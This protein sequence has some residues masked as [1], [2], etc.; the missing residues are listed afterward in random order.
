VGL[1]IRQ[2][3]G[4]L[5]LSDGEHTI[6]FTAADGQLDVGPPPQ[7]GPGVITLTGPPEVWAEIATA[8][9][10]PFLHDAVTAL[11]RGLTRSGD[12]LIWW[13]YAPAVQRVVE[14]LGPPRPGAPLAA[15]DQGP[16]P[17]F[18]APVGRYVHLTLGSEANPGGADHRIYYEEAGQGI[19]LLCQHTA[20]SHGTQWR[21][22]LEN[23]RITDHFRVIAYDLPFHGKS[24]PPTGRA[25]W[26]ETYN[27]TGSFLRSVPV[28]LARALELD[29]PVFMG[30][31]VGGLL[32]LDLALEH[33]DD[34]RAVISLEGALHI[35]GD[36]GR[37][38]GF[39]DP[40][41]SNETKARMMQGLTSPTSPLAYRKETIQTYA[42]GWPPAF[43][44]DLWYY[45][46]DYDLRERAGQIDT[47]R[48]GVHILSG[49]YDSSGTPAHGRAA[50]DAIAGSTFAEMDGVGHFPMSENPEAFFPYLEPIL[51]RIRADRP[52]TA[53]ATAPGA[54]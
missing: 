37:L 32:A 34:F 45:I 2:W 42:S 25:W 35:G 6:G 48:V 30:C 33:P 22:V 5:R 47:D 8:V 12:E 49:E 31:S 51:D 38:T 54:P 17:R 40:R 26:D 13:Q 7:D 27:L 9:P 15:S 52:A 20:G 1:A 18:D 46:V 19:P 14:L 53:E 29:R 11:G 21:H 44:G 3:Q 41:V 4:G 36:H 16:T 23:P 50:H 43:L 10:E 39:W 24:V 28:E